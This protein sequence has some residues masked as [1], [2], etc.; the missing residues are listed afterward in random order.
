MPFVAESCKQAIRQKLP[1]E[2]LLRDYNINLVPSGRKFKALCPFHAEKTPSFHVDVEKQYYYCFGCQ[3]GGDLFRFI[4]SMHRVDFP[5]AL[6]I[7]ARRAG[8]D[9]VY[10]SPQGTASGMPG[11]RG[12]TLLEMH[13]ALALAREFYHRFLLEAR[14]AEPAREYLR[15]R[16]ITPEM[17]E[18]FQIGFS[19]TDWDTFVTVASRKGIPA[20]MLETVGLARRRSEGSGLYDY[21]RGRVMFPITDPQDRM[22]GF[23]GRTL[24]DDTPKYLNTPK[25]PLFD[26]S[27]VLYGLAQA[28]MGIRRE[29]R[30]GIVEGYTDAIMAHQAGLDFFVASL[31]TAFTTENARRL[32]RLAPRA[33]LVFDGDDAGQRASERSLDLLIEESL[34]VRIYTVRDGKDPCDA[35]LA[36]GGEE[37]RRRFDGDSVGL[38]EFKWRRTVGSQEVED[39]GPAVKARALDE[40]LDLLGR[41]PN[42]VA[43]KLY[44]REFS[45]RL[46]VPERDIEA[47]M[48]QVA[49]RSRRETPER[50]SA[51]EGLPGGRTPGA[52]EA[53]GELWTL[54][55]TA[56]ECILALPHR[57]A[58]VWSRVPRAVF[59]APPLTTLAAAVGRLLVDGALSPPGLVASVEDPEASRLLVQLLSRIEDRDGK[60]SRDYEQAWVGLQRDIQRYERRT[61]AAELKRLVKTEEERGGTESLERLRRE[62]FDA[63]REL[64]KV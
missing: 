4:Q 11:G 27:Q 23:G 56:L 8:V 45:E 57:A 25:T 51:G 19:P 64:K 10:D 30:I 34:D 44:L 3:E 41:V 46:G 16:R 12:R 52:G 58:E 47:R 55:E 43:R 2:D 35:I 60:P 17:W 50:P 39:A 1:L 22:I 53:R 36:L 42:I 33:L 28:R 38:F 5:Q 14:A 32:G 9:L 29:G 21:F 7:L 61:R 49:R 48:L 54:G 37:F 13:D 15:R 24:G 40:F 31:G 62:Y 6:E 26:K 63:L 18:R 20:Q 59:E